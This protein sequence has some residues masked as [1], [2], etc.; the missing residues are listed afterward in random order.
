MARDF[1]YQIN[2]HFWTIQ[3]EGIHAGKTAIFIRLQGCPVGCHWCDSKT[4]WYK[5]GSSYTRDEIR[6]MILGYPRAG[7][8]VI[9]GGEP[10]IHDLDNLITLIRQTDSR[11]QIT[12]ETSGA[13]GFKGYCRPGWITLSPKAAADWKIDH[14][15]LTRANEIKFVIDEQFNPGIVKSIRA[16]RAKLNP[17]PAPIV[18]MPEGAP[19]RSEM[20][21]RTLDLLASE[22]PEARFGPRLQY[23]YPEIGKQEGRNNLIISESDARSEARE[24]VRGTDGNN[25]N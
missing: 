9:T 24:M 11:T 3:G 5:G 6:Q 25:Q 21:I 14:E 4:T 22:F 10:L 15:V 16:Q 19:P 13:F 17:D 23:D 18:F 8:V 20:I 12:L 2:E 7:Q 1:R